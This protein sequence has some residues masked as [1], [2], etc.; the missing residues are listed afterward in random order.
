MAER[1]SNEEV[2]GG[3]GALIDQ[4]SLGAAVIDGAGEPRR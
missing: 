2:E 3:V 1:Y 4:S